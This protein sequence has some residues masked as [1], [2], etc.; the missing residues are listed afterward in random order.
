MADH[1]NRRHPA[2]IAILIYALFGAAWTGF[3]RRIVPP[4]IDAAYH[5]KSHDS[6]NAIFQ[7]TSRHPLGHYLH[8]WSDFSGAVLLAALLHLL[9]V[10]IVVS[11]DRQRA[12]SRPAIEVRQDAQLSLALALFALAFLALTVLSGPRHDYVADLEIWDVVLRG[13]DPWWLIKD[14][15]FPINAYGPLFNTIGLLVVINPLTPKL[16]F[17]F[18]YI[19]FVVFLLK[20]TRLDPTAPGIS[21]SGLIALALNPFP[22]VE[23]AYFGHFDILV[24]MACVAAV[25]WRVRGRDVL[26]GLS[27][28]AGVLLKYLPLVILPCLVLEGRRVRFR[29]LFASL[30]PILLGMAASV[31]VW[32]PAT[33]RPIGF[34]ASRGS[35]YLS[36]FRFLRGLA[37]PLRLFTDAPTNLDWLAM[38]CLLAALP[39]VF[40]L[41]WL[42]RIEPAKSSAI[43]VLTTLLFY[44]VGFPQYQMVL[45]L[46]LA[47]AIGAGP[48]VNRNPTDMFLNVTFTCYF[49]W[50]SIF[51]LFNSAVGGVL[52][53]GDRWG[54][55]EE[56]VGL[57]TFVLGFLLLAALLRSTTRP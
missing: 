32:G 37:S 51:D 1:H 27:L 11:I 10:L 54:W 3:S 8:L 45:L 23:I 39:S 53:P 17:S 18:T 34:A 44:Q 49:G 20:V 13:G 4:I 5:G 35:N 42:R 25:H 12:R 22:W 47:Y 36:I 30:I 28:A 31:L 14:R 7:R 48:K 19:Y 6:L 9:L 24:G 41:C 26:S 46:L 50:L 15:G 43:V 16:L 33:F 21:R 55:V 29:V 52:H 40:A 2:T 57:P 56:V 38:P